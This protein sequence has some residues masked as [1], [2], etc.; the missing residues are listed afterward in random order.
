MARPIRETPIL[1]GKNARRLEKAM[2]EAK[3][4]SKEKLEAMRKEYEEFRSKL[5]IKIQQQ[6][7]LIRLTAEYE[8]KPFDCGD[9]DLNG[10]LNC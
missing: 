7:D 2:R 8:L 5:T 6:M 9:T 4:F 3:P 1:Y 10:F